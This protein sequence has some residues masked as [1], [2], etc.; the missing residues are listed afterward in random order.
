[1]IGM[2]YTMNQSKRAVLESTSLKI[3]ALGEQNLEAL[4]LQ[5]PPRRDVEVRGS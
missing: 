4:I 3:M 5:P 2:Y 1:M